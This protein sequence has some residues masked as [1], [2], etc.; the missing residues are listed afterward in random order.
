MSRRRPFW[1][2]V[3]EKLLW[4]PVSLRLIGAAMLRH[5][6]EMWIGDSHAMSSN[7][8]IVS[9]SIMN[10]ADGTFIIRLGARLMYSLAT[11][12]F[13]AWSIR[14]AR[15]VGRLCAPGQIVP[16]FMAGEI[17]VRAHL[18]HHAERGY[19]FVPLYAER[20]S[21]FASVLRA[22]KFVIAL[23]PPPCDTN[24]FNI[25]YP[26]VGSIEERLEAWRS[27]RSAVIQAAEAV[28]AD[29]LDFSADVGLPDGSLRPELSDDGAHTNEAAIPLI[30]AAVERLVPP[31][32]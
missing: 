10:G 17:D 11:S 27:L 28:G 21:Q 2:R 4:I 16:I 7:R 8:S 32:R 13:P 29:V 5:P 25:W 23:P 20:C 26:V 19:A 24:G 6:V 30:R 9:A 18:V 31:A 14:L 1:R 3:S 12:G 22:N 15:V